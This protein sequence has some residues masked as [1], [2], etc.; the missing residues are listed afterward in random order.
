MAF[1]C[2]NSSDLI[3]LDDSLTDSH[4]RIIDELSMLDLGE[5]NIEII[6]D[7]TWIANLL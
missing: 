5:N 2:M 6:F 7:E 4:P 3:G 1:D